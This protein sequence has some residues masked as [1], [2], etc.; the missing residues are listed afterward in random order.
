MSVDELPGMWPGEAEEPER[1]RD[2]SSAE[3]SEDEPITYDGT[4]PFIAG[5]D[6]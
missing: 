6:T 2:P 5:E 1:L 4:M 3:A